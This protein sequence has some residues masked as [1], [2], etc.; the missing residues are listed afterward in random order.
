MAF[1]FGTDDRTVVGWQ[2][3][4]KGRMEVCGGARALI[5]ADCDYSGVNHGVRGSDGF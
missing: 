1:D 5:M 4:V 3:S 2:T